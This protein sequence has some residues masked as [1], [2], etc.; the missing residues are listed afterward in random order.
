MHANKVPVVQ[1]LRA[2]LL[3]LSLSFLSAALANWQ[4]CSRCW[5]GPGDLN[6]R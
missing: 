4:Y 1:K 6:Y 3:L 2:A 5:D